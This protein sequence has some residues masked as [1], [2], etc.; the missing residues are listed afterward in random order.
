MP[1]DIE[2][3]RP[4]PLRPIREVAAE[5]GLEEPE[6]EPYGRHKAKVRLEAL[7]DR[8]GDGGRLVL[9]TG[10]TP[11][12][13]GEGEDHGVHRAGGWAATPRAAGGPLPLGAQPRPRLR[14]QGRGHRR[15]RPRSSPWRTSTSTSPPADGAGF[16]V[17]RTGD[18]L[19]M[20]GLPARPAAHDMGV[21]PGGEIFGLA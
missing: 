3:A 14:P 11:T 8:D 12:P 16:V 17:A 21:G 20:P 4:A 5:M 18:V 7:A 10:M 9:V 2:I 1:S 19:L 13:P 6:F 15:R